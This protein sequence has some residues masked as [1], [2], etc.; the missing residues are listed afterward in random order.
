MESIQSHD[1]RPQHQIC[2]LGPD[3]RYSTQFEG[4]TV[5]M[6]LCGSNSN[7]SDLSL[8]YAQLIQ[9][10][11]LAAGKNKPHPYAMLPPESYHATLTGIASRSKFHSCDDYNHHVASHL[12]SIEKLCRALGALPQ[13]MISFEVVSFEMNCR[14]IVLNITPQTLESETY[15]RTCEQL[16]M[17]ILASL[18]QKQEYH[19][20]LAYKVPNTEELTED[21]REPLVRL[22]QQLQG[23]TLTFSRP[24]VCSY[25]S[26]LQFDP[27]LFSNEL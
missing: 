14:V 7:T 6:P 1:N 23:T 11:K 2:K 18:F 15:I 4:L 3:G 8:L 17:K 22:L 9:A 10:Q 5:V 25:T 21:E 19:I 20:T 26:M 13:A 16:S 27:L 12:G 24:Q